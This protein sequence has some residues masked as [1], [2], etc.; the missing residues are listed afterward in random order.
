MHK[1]SKIKLSILLNI[2]NM[3]K[4]TYFFEMNK[5][6]KDDKNNDI[7]EEIRTIFEN[8]KRN[9]GVRRVYHVLK[10]RDYLINHKKVQRIMK[11]NNFSA[12]KHAQKYHSYQ[13]TVGAVAK[14]LIKRDFK[15]DSPNMKWTTDISQFSTSF[16]KC[17]LSPL[18][19]MFNDEIIAY[20]LSL[21]ANFNQIER[22]LNDAKFDCKDVSKL[23]IHSDQGWQYQNPRYVEKL[24]N[25]NIKQSMS[26]K[27]NCYDNSI[28]ESFFGIMKNEMFYG[29]ENEYKSFAEFKKVVEEYIYYYNNERIKEKTGWKSPVQFRLNHEIIV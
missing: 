12:R 4:S 26:R 27:G 14:N 1:E 3:S 18:M 11:L 28:M 7:I 20:D 9:Y 6:D 24:K 17:Y 16:G 25:F 29:H 8:S 10:N 5:I 15:I 23:I 22:M 2:S 21:K 19:D 13:G